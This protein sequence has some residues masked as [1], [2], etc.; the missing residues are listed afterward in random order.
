MSDSPRQRLE[1]ARRQGPAALAQACAALL[2][3]S[4]GLDPAAANRALAQ[5]RELSGLI[6]AIA[7]VEP[8][9]ARL[10]ELAAAARC[11]GCAACCRTSSPTLYA[12]DLPRLRAAGL[13]WES[14]VTLRAGE[15][16]HSA[17]LGGLRTLEQELIKLREQGGA[18]AWLGAKGCAIYEQRPLQCRWLECWS[19]RHAGQLADRPR[20]GREE[21]LAG[22]PTALALAREYELKLPAAG[23][24]QALAGAAGGQ[25]E[26]TTQALALLE[27]D[28]GLR[29]AISGRYGYS[30]DALYCILG[31]P[32]RE[33]AAN[34]GLVLAVEKD[35]PVLRRQANQGLS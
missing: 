2:A 16:V 18:C 1:R 34:Y 13:G 10:G 20:L 23:L 30:A 22:D 3:A 5:N 31:R 7:P 15:R 8:L 27:L 33:V 32:A 24:H 21:L 17:R 4:R 12:E 35:R 26:A 19:G 9:A 11:I 25:A 14:L 28:H 6:A 29:A